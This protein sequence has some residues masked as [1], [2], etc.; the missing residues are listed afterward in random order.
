MLDL[1]PSVESVESVGLTCA[2]RA[3]CFWMLCF[4]RGCARH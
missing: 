3:R 2:G 4:A 1:A